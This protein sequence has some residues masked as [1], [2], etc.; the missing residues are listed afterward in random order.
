MT[1][2]TL[3]ENAARES[4]E[5]A[6]AMIDSDHRDP[7]VTVVCGRGNNGGDGYA[8]A[9]LLHERGFHTRLL[10][11]GEPRSGSDAATNARKAQLL[12]LER[13]S[14]PD[15]LKS[16]TLIVDALLGT[17]L[18]RS[19]AGEELGLIEAINATGAPVLSIDIPSGLD[20]DTGRPLNSAVR[21]TETVTFVG[22]KIGL[23]E[24]AGEALAGRIRVVDIGIPRE[25]ARSLALNPPNDGTVS[26][27]E[28]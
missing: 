8:I 26:D 23:L 25:L 3:M 10:S 6:L 18:D 7:L 28:L 9:R 19:V 15:I 22:L 17:G 1:G 5:V 14:D 27:T 20:A 13:T 16:S 12:G 21:A 11:S 2:L 4:F 24:P